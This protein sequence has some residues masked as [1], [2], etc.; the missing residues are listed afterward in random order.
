M[1]VAYAALTFV[2]SVRV[3]EL[4]KQFKTV[5]PKCMASKNKGLN[6]VCFA[7]FAKRLLMKRNK[8]LTNFTQ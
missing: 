7:L 5:L 6:A 4:K 8:A 2:R 1:H 3:Y